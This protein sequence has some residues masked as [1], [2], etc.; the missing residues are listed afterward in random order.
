M[1]FVVGWGERERE[2]EILIFL[3][4]LHTFI[5][6]FPHFASQKLKSSTTRS[7]LSVAFLANSLTPVFPFSLCQQLST[8]LI[9]LLRL[10]L[11]LF[12][13]QGLQFRVIIICNS[14]KCQSVPSQVQRGHCILD[15]RPGEC[16]QKPIFNHPSHIHC[17][18]RSLSHKQENS[19]V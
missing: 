9:S 16:N 1:H 11:R 8:L 10:L 14:Q 3:N 4:L 15:H 18:S 7:G 19:Q 5:S 2:R 6:Q 13:L 17:Q 12:G